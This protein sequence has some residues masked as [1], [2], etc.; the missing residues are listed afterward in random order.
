MRAACANTSAAAHAL[1]ESSSTGAASCIATATAPDLAELLWTPSLTKAAFFADHWETRHAHWR[2][3]DRLDP[4]YADVL[5]LS[6]SQALDFVDSMDGIGAKRKGAKRKGKGTVA[7]HIRLASTD[8]VKCGPRARHCRFECATGKGCAR[9]KWEDGWSI[10]VSSAHLLVRPLLDLLHAYW[11]QF[12]LYVNANLYMSPTGSG[13]FGYHADET[14]VF[15]LQLQGEKR[16]EVCGRLMPDVNEPAV[17]WDTVDV[18][19]GW[20]LDLIANCTR[21]DLKRGDVLYLPIGTL[22]RAHGVGLDSLHCTIGMDRTFD[23]KGK[24]YKG[25]DWSGFLALAALGSSDD[26]E[27]A[28]ASTRRFVRW[29]NQVASTETTGALRRLP[30]SWST[31]ALA[32]APAETPGTIRWSSNAFVHSVDPATDL[33]CLKGTVQ[34]GAAGC[35]SLNELLLHEYEEFV[36]PILKQHSRESSEAIEHLPQV[37]QH[38]Q[39]S[40]LVATLREVRT[41]MQAT[42]PPLELAAGYE[43]EAKMRRQAQAADALEAAG[44]VTANTLVRRSRGVRVFVEHDPVA[45]STIQL[46]AN[47]PG[48][49]WP[50]DVHARWA[51]P[52]TWALS[53]FNGAAGRAFHAQELYAAVRECSW[54]SACAIRERETALHVVRWL[55]GLQ[56]VQVVGEE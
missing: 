2:A 14:D 25:F 6:V 20:Y 50:Q 34:H 54:G 28:L 23:E 12:G 48:T 52:V 9:R 42:M 49:K 40:K 36:E 17:K 26:S 39:S 46:R 47:V 1:G 37:K 11:R 43:R 35:S 51:I 7:T 16:W 5:E 29:I 27:Q 10:V 56:L 22:H 45:W 38:L 4:S 24:P 55:V 33:P 18:S 21:V 13:A 44:M 53:T 32:L 41:R 19:A 3:V 31:D 30:W 15:V 8:P